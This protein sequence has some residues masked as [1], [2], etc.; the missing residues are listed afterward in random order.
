[1]IKNYLEQD[2]EKH[3]EINILNS[4]YRR[5]ISE[6]YEKN[7]TMFKYTLPEENKQISALKYKLYLPTEKELERELTRE[8]EM[9]E[10]VKRL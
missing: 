10:M 6:N 1:M 5:N 8:S 2:F 3:I 4:G 7:E 9:I